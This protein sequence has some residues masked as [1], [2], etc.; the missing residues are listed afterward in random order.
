MIWYQ[1]SQFVLFIG[2]C[3]ALPE[4]ILCICRAIGYHWHRLVLL[5][6]TAGLSYHQPGLTLRLHW[7]SPQ[8]A[9]WFDLTTTIAGMIYCTVQRSTKH[10]CHS[11]Y[12]EW[13]DPADTDQTSAFLSW[14]IHVMASIASLVLI[15]RIVWYSSHTAYRGG[16]TD[17]VCSAFSTSCRPSY[18]TALNYQC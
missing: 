6:G 10:V 2:G 13:L 17:L 4:Y 18:S 3:T 1:S 7:T 8:A 5:L 12:T 14:S 9:G 16:Q 11:P 15:Y